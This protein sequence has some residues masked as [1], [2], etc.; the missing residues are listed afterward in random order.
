MFICKKTFTWLLLLNCCLFF[1]KAFAQQSNTLTPKEKAD[2]WQLLFDGKDLIG[3]HSYL[4]KE[5][6]K[7][8][9]VQNGLIVLNKNSKSVHKDFADLVTDAEYENFDLKLEWKMEPCA[10]SGVMFYVNESPLYKNTYETG[11][12]MQITDLSCLYTSDHHTISDSRI[13]LHRAGALYDLAPADTEWVNPAPK[14][15]EYEIIAN[16]G[17]VQ[18]FQNGHK[19]VDAKFWDY[20]WWKLISRTKFHQWPDFGTFRKGHISFQGTED[21]K[22]WFRNIKIKTFRFGPAG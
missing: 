10:N 19:V 2:G 15:N 11:P 21:G 16:N 22:L 1:N 4:E 13:H 14:W 8:W 20:P 17:H 12:E 9:E 18:L 7:A 5:P 3:W 6:G